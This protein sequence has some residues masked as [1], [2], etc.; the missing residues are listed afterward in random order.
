MNNC[1]PNLHTNRSHWS[2]VDYDESYHLQLSIDDADS[3]VLADFPGNVMPMPIIT[4][5]MMMKKLNDQNHEELFQPNES[6]AFGWFMTDD[7][8]DE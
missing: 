3:N 8:S 6:N 7:E 2:F 5:N 1:S 4:P